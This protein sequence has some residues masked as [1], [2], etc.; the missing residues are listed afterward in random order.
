MPANILIVDDDTDHARMVQT[1]LESSG[2][3]TSTVNDGLSAL[4]QVKT[5]MPDLM[6]LDVAMPGLD[7]WQV[8][9]Q[10][11][12]DT[13]IAGLPVILLTAKTEADDIAMSWHAGADLYLKKPFSAPTLLSFV[14]R[15]LNQT[16]KPIRGKSG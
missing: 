11:R 15:L 16:R 4:E 9:R 8:L 1:T 14:E 6:V 2:Y 7:G 3:Q 12:A 10:L 13:S 5:K